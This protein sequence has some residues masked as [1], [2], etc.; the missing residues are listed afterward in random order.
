LALNLTDLKKYVFFELLD[1]A[2]RVFIHVSCSGDV[3]IGERGF[4]AEE[5]E[6]GLVLVFNSKMKFEWNEE[7]ISATLGFGTRTEKCFIPPDSIMS[8]FS[9]DLNAHFSVSGPAPES[10]QKNQAVKKVHSISKQKVIKVDFSR[11]S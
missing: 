6:K 9:P 8:V 10:D 3:L 2:G 1:L 11:K 7:G 4:L 5:K